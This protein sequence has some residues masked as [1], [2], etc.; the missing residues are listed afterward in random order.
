[1]NTA[2]ENPIG[3]TIKAPRV[4]P[5][6]ARG[7]ISAWPP[8]W[9]TENVVPAEAV[10]APEALSPTIAEVVP[11]TSKPPWPPR[12]VELAEWPTDLRQ[13]W[14]EL[15][16]RLEDEGV[17]FPESERQAF[18]QVNAESASLG[19]NLDHGCTRPDGST[20]GQLDQGVDVRRATN[21]RADQLNARMAW[22]PNSPVIGGIGRYQAP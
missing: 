21:S 14:G 17:P 16:N 22:V 18:M 9:M 2:L 13:R 10:S 7:E 8:P 12:P 11:A 4:A 15:A 5:R 20:G 1:M 19:R 3:V 6:G